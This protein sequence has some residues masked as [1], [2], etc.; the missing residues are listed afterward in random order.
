[1]NYADPG[2]IAGATGSIPGLIC[3][4]VLRRHRIKIDNTRS[5]LRSEMNSIVHSAL[6]EYKVECAEQ[7]A[8]LGR[9]VETLERN[10]QNVDEAG[11][12]GLTRSV[13]S[14]AMH[15]LRSGMPPESAASVLG[16]GK[17]EM[18]LIARVSGIL[19]LK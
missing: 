18:R 13:R 7:I 15:L 11:K 8:Q 3:L 14:Q 16:I 12:G 19:S 17:R 4:L 5:E 9:N 2:L 1:M 10:A 6:N